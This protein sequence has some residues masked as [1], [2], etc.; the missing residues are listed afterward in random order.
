MQQICSSSYQDVS[1]KLYTQYKIAKSCPV[2]S[3]SFVHIS[4]VGRSQEQTRLQRAE[5]NVLIN[6]GVGIQK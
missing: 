4:P 2:G 3:R 1:L 5:P 6:Y